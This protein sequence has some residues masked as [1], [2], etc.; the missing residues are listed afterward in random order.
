MLSLL[1]FGIKDPRHIAR[2]PSTNRASNVKS[3]APSTRTLYRDRIA[4]RP[5]YIPLLP[6][7]LFKH[8][9]IIRSLL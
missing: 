7:K 3:E 9:F 4:F 6:L 8:A 5:L 2:L 1:L